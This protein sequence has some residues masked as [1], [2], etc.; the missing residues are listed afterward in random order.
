MRVEQCPRQ[1]T[2]ED[3]YLGDDENAKIVEMYI[4]S[5]QYINSYLI[6]YVRCTFTFSIS[7]L[8]T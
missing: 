1:I 3:D 4:F 8:N 5:A 6:G 2:I 7:I